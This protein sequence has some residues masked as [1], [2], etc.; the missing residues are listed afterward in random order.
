MRR[1]PRESSGVAPGFRFFNLRLT[2]LSQLL[3]SFVD[4]GLCGQR[5]HS[6]IQPQ[7]SLQPI[8]LSSDH[9]AG[10]LQLLSKLLC[11]LQAALHG[12]LQ[13]PN[14]VAQLLTLTAHLPKHLPRHMRRATHGEECSTDSRVSEVTVRTCSFDASLACL[15]SSFS[16]NIRPLSF[17]ICLV[18][19]ASTNQHKA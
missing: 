5:L 13:T 14:C 4:E 17:V 3:T 7:P 18:T 12:A 15:P 11:L 9:I 2:L 1:R 10:V 6:T 16:A 8:N 19:F